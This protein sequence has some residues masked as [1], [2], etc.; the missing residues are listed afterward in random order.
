MV[1]GLQLGEQRILRVPTAVGR[2]A[3]GRGD[4]LS[5]FAA[6]ATN[7]LAPSLR[8]YPT[9]WYIRA[10]SA[11]EARVANS[12]S[13]IERGKQS[14][15]EPALQVRDCR[16]IGILIEA[17]DEVETR[18]FEPGHEIGSSVPFQFGSHP[19][20]EVS[21]P[22]EWR[23]GPWVRRAKLVLVGGC[24]SGGFDEGDQ[25][26]GEAETD[27]RHRLQHDAVVSEDRL[28]WIVA[29]SGRR[30]VN[31]Q[32]VWTGGDRSVFERDGGAVDARRRV[33]V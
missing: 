13:L 11:S 31:V 18:G 22:V 32:V 3:V 29:Q 26:G 6:L 12:S 4:R 7:R 14:R 15:E 1:L 17:L 2:C 5:G 24:P 28:R 30:T 23:V 16:L 33:R 8:D 25:P 21:C 27:P 9:G 20:Q 19:A 10:R